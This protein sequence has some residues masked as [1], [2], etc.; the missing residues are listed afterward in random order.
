MPNIDQKLYQHL[1]EYYKGQDLT[2]ESM[3]V[4]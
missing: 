3:S 1:T 2:K 4:R